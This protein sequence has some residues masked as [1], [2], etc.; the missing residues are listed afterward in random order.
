MSQ[1]NVEIVKAAHPPSGTDVRSLFADDPYP[2]RGALSRPAFRGVAQS[3]AHRREA[4]LCGAPHSAFLCDGEGQ[5]RTGD[6]TIF[7]QEPGREDWPWL[8]GLS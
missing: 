3:V 8:Q 2:A 4:A 1:E 6:T 7:S 5:N